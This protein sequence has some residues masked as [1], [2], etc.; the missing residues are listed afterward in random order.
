MPLFTLSASIGRVPIVAQENQYAQGRST[1]EGVWIV[2][3]TGTKTSAGSMTADQDVEYAY[4]DAD[5]DA[6]VGPGSECALQAYEVIAAGAVCV[7]APVAEAGGAQAG[8]QTLTWTTL[9]SGAGTLYLWTEQGEISWAVDTASKENTA[10]N[11]VAAINAKTKLGYTAAK[12]AGPDYTVTLTT[13]SKGVRMNDF[14]TKLITTEAPTGNSTAHA[15][16]T[17]TTS[18]MVPFTGGSGA[19]NATTVLGLLENA[20]YKRIAFAQNDATNAA[21]LETYLDAQSGALVEHLEQG[22]VGHNGAYSAAASI[23]QTTL[24]AFLC[25]L[26]WCRYSV[27]H[28]SQIAARVAAVRAVYE[29]QNPNV[30]A[31]GTFNDPASK[32]WTTNPQLAADIPSHAEL[33]VALAAG[34]TPVMPFAGT[35]RIVYSITTYSLNGTDP[36]DR[37]W[38]TQC[39][40]VPQ[41]AREQ[42]GAL[43]QEFLESNPGVG[44]DLPDGRPQI[45]GVGTPSLWNASATKLHEDLVTAGYLMAEDDDGNESVPI[46]A[47]NSSSTPKR[48]DT[49]FP[50][51]VRP[52]QLQ[53]ANL[54]RQVAA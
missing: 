29:Q 25:Q 35:T 30:R 36:D 48:I 1:G 14:Y 32:L 23:A 7:L 26:A 19:D 3:C 18:G 37:C 17:P 51:I 4:S 16:G 47:Y 5:V 10:D 46:S 12:G 27:R 31:A 20:E 38:G 54:I 39:V 45:E 53:L 11:C 22:V 2:A 41:Y 21:L 28:S 8:T 42:L 49:I 33:N 13:K 44:P 6:Y 40:T 9:G 52:H 50:C 43:S 34:V 24:N 15:G